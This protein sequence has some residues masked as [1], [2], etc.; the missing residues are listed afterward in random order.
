L[1]KK[2]FF[3]IIILKIEKKEDL[4]MA[5]IPFSKLDAKINN[6]VNQS[7]YCNSKGE[8]I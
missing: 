5:K 4:V 3:D 1:T 7:S 6:R 2:N 8:E